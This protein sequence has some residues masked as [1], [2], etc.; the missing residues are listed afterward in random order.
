MS[1]SHIDTIENKLLVAYGWKSSWTCPKNKDQQDK[2]SFHQ[3]TFTDNTRQASAATIRA[4]QVTSNAI[5]SDSS[6]L[7]HATTSYNS[8]ENPPQLLLPLC[9]KT[10]SRISSHSGR[11]PQDASKHEGC[12]QARWDRFLRC[13]TQEFSRCSQIHASRSQG[14]RHG[15]IPG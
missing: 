3:N 11:A 10:H 9:N 4:R 12:M 13:P 6:W 7:N 5:S 2:L 14:R 8:I 15:R 1:C